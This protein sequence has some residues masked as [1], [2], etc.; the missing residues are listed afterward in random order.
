MH[1]LL[2]VYH[3]HAFDSFFTIPQLLLAITSSLLTIYLTNSTTFVTRKESGVLAPQFA[4]DK[5]S[6]SPNVPA[7]KRK[8]LYYVRVSYYSSYY[9]PSY[10]NLDR[11]LAVVF[12]RSRRSFLVLPVIPL[13]VQR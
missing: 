8:V 9:L 4:E 2:Y 1:L 3:L 7:I 12:L 11:L 13:A 6:A 10:V 5:S